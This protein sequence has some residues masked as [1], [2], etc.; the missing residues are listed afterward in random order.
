MR[1]FYH[2]SAPQIGRQKIASRG[3]AIIDCKMSSS[4]PISGAPANLLGKSVQ[5]LREYLQSLGEPA[6]RGA[7]IYHALYAERRF[8][9]AAM[10]NLPSELRERLTREAAIALP[11]IVRRHESSD[12][13]VRYVLALGA[14]DAM[15]G[16]GAGATKAAT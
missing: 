3:H 7:Q 6:Y 16:A 13:T 8:E 12:G 11:R 5:E 15:R 1:I 9:L 2:I 14:A 10:S 4:T